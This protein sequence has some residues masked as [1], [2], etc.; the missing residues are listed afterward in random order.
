MSQGNVLREK[1]N[2]AFVRAVEKMEY[3]VVRR[4]S[5]TVMAGV[6]GW[7]NQQRRHLLP[8]NR[9]VLRKSSRIQ[10]LAAEMKQDRKKKVIMTVLNRQ[11]WNF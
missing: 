5:R 6:G 1:V 8:M 11:I 3:S 7:K 2:M 4:V 9:K 10:K